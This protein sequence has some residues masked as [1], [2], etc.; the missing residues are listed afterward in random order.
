M[1]LQNRHF[2][3]VVRVLKLQLL[4]AVCSVVITAIIVSNLNSIYSSLIGCVIAIVP[5]VAYVLIAFRDGVVVSPSKAFQNHKNA[6]MVRFL[7]NVLLFVL[8]CVLYKN[9]NYLTLFSSF[10]VV[11]SAYWLSIAKVGA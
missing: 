8:T 3:V 9:C 1:R 2:A 11:L 7:L 6:F 10:C 5:T 4:L